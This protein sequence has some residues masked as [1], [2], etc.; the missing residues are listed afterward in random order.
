MGGDGEVDEEEEA[1]SES[2]KAL[3][4][5]NEEYSGDDDEEADEE[6]DDDDDE[7]PAME[8]CNRLVEDEGVRRA[9]IHTKAKTKT[10]NNTLEKFLTKP[11][12]VPCEKVKERE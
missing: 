1:R 4:H 10:K 5:N 3:R 12:D 7:M 11:R 8:N 6:D 2:R 9:E